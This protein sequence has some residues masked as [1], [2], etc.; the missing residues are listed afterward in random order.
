MHLSLIQY[1]HYL[2]RYTYCRIIANILSFTPS[3]CIFG[4]Y[5]IVIFAMYTIVRFC[6][7]TE[8]VTS[9]LNEKLRDIE[10]D[11]YMCEEVA[12]NWS[13]RE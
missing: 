2:W 13:E 5:A 11:I 3:R 9:I 1:G 7:V 6:K 10:M 4:S 12:N 8:P